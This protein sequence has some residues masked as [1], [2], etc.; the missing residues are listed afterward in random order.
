M[1]D[2]LAGKYNTIYGR[3]FKMA[4]KILQSFNGELEWSSNDYQA[5]T[6]KSKKLKLIFYPHKTSAGN[7][8]IRVR[9]TGKNIGSILNLLYSKSGFNCTF[10]HKYTTNYN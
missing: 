9:G 7:Y 5:F 3:E 10:S 8:H 1:E 4:K 6:F 2:K